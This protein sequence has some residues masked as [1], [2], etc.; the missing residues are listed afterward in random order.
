MAC[1]WAPWD[2]SGWILSKYLSLSWSL[3]AEWVCVLLATQ[4]VY[5]M[6]LPFLNWSVTHRDVLALSLKV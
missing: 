6:F 1:S 5:L 2:L 3:L 4:V